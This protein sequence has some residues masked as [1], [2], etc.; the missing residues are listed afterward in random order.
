MVKQYYDTYYTL[1]RSQWSILSVESGFGHEKEVSLGSSLI[2]EQYVAFYYTGRPD[3]VAMDRDNRIFPV[4][5]KT[6]D[7]IRSGLDAKFKPHTETAGY[8]YAIQSILGKPVDRCVINV[9]G[10]E[11]PAE[12]RDKSKEANPRFKRI[13]PFYAPEELDEWNHNAWKKCKAIASLVLSDEATW[14]MLETQCFQYNA[15]C[16]FHDVDR[17]PFS[18]RETVIRAD[19]VTKDPWVPYK[20]VKDAVAG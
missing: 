2:G 14:P 11:I 8:I 3:I 6:T 10:R 4:D 5:H 7:A 12:P 17:V 13:H 19:Y 1:D 18:A 9:C 20:K 15:P 16:E